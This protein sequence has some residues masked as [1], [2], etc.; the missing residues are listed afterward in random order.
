MN[1]TKMSILEGKDFYHRFPQSLPINED[2]MHTISLLTRRDICN[3]QILMT[4][5]SNMEWI[6][7]WLGMFF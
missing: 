7:P 2:L 4:T 6:N 1:K 3:I 5:E